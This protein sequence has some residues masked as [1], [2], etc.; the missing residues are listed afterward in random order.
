MTEARGHLAH[1]GSTEWLPTE[2]PRVAPTLMTAQEA[3]V[4]LRLDEGDR[5]MADALKSLEYLVKAGRI[6]PCRVGR[7]N[8]FARAELHRFV[9]EQ[10]ERYRRPSASDVDQEGGSR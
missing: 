10:T 2:P 6:R 5:D 1:L 3:V 7:S 4:Y 9:I 8:R